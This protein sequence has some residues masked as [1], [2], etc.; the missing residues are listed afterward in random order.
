[1]VFTIMAEKLKG[2]TSKREDTDKDADK[3]KDSSSK[4]K[5]NGK[6]AEKDEE[7]NTEEYS[8]GNIE[9]DINRGSKGFKDSSEDSDCNHKKS[10]KKAPKKR[11]VR[12]NFGQYYKGQRHFFTGTGCKYKFENVQDEEARNYLLMIFKK[13]K[14]T[15]HKRTTEQTISWKEL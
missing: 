8:D 15:S 7:S 5:D 3:Q 13:K 6:D 4:E 14:K 11:R 12:Y 2:N 1:M 10:N 9:K